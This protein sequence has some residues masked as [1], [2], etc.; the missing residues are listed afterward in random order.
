VRLEAAI[1][2]RLGEREAAQ[3]LRWATFEAS[4]NAGIL[5]EYIAALSDFEEFDAL[6]RAFAHALLA[7]RQYN[8]LTLF[9]DWA[10]LDLAAKLV[11][12][13]QG[14]WD[15]RHYHVLSPA[16]EMLEEKHPL[17]A[18]LIYRA[19]I[20]DIL[21]RGNSQAYGHAARY[22]KKLDLLAPTAD[23]DP[24]RSATI[25]SH[26]YYRTSIQKAHGRKVG[27]WSLVRP[28]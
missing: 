4:L 28:G 16:A 20:D 14:S 10:R 5:R 6:D 24:H 22:L 1:L 13:Y 21:A 23:A 19:L 9:L 11:T 2:T 26:A 3:A 15:G 18:T 25:S 8:A 7:G 27:F 12:E 17:A